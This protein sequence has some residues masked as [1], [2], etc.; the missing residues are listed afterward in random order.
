MFRELF[1]VGSNVIL[2]KIAG[3]P[4]GYQAFVDFTDGYSYVYPSDWRVRHAMDL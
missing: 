3:V 2:Y 4:K 1:P